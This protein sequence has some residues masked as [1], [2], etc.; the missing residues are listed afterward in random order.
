MADIIDKTQAVLDE[1]EK[2]GLSLSRET[3]VICDD[4]VA[5]IRAEDGEL[6]E[7]GISMI[8]CNDILRLDGFEVGITPEDIENWQTME[9]VML[10]MIE[11]GE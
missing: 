4:T 9:S 2:R 5:F 11:D 10:D 6:G 8:L 3:A 7:S 1:I